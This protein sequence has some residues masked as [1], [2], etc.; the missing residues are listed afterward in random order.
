[1]SQQAKDQMRKTQ[2][3]QLIFMIMIAVITVISPAGVG[4]YFFLNALFGLGQSY[5][6]HVF[7]VKRRS[8]KRVRIEDIGI[9]N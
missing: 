7:I 4:L 8:S 2:M 6:L 1:M 5:L 9:M 3:T